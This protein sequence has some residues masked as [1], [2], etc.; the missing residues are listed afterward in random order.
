[1][2]RKFLAGVLAALTASV[3]NQAQAKVLVYEGFDATD[4]SLNETSHDTLSSKSLTTQ[5]A[6]IG[7]TTTSWGAMGARRSRRSARTTDSI[8]PRI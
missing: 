7:T 8:S 1:M 3:V 4:Y 6:A 2:K 5:T